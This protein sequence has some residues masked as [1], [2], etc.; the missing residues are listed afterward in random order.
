MAAQA[1]LAAAAAQLREHGFGA[2]SDAGAAPAAAAAP[3]HAVKAESQPDGVPGWV[4]TTTAAAA[5]AAA[6]ADGDTRAGE[7]DGV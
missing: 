2:V 7:L 6:A 1:R 5:A 3:G 4:P